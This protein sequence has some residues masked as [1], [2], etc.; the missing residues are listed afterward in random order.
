MHMHMH[1]AYYPPILSF[2]PTLT[3]E[4][5]GGEAFYERHGGIP[6]IYTAPI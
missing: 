5:G 4:E 1:Y 6:T 3:L 2:P